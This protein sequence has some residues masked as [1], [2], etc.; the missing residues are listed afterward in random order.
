MA[1]GPVLE[2]ETRNPLELARIAGDQDEALGTSLSGDH[3]IVSPDGGTFPFEFGANLAGLI[4]RLC[5]ELLEIEARGETLQNAEVAF[6]MPGLL[7]SV[8][9]FKQRDGRDRH[10]ALIGRQHLP[11]RTRQMSE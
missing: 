7:G 1:L 11:D 2:P 3:E 6:D 10:A 8:S 9:E 4:R 5:I